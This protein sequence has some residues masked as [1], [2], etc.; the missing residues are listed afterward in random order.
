MV[1]NV[2]SLLALAARSA[3]VSDACNCTTKSL[4][5]WEGWP[6]SLREDQF[7]KIGSLVE[8]A[9]EDSTLDEYHP[10]GTSFWSPEAPI[11]A[12]Y[13]PYNRC[14]LWECL[15]CSRVY[16]HY[17]DDGAYHSESRVRALDPLLIVDVPL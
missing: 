1:L 16:L 13:Y 11:A 17:N 7:Q 8:A 14:D 4:V 6:A 3:A 10:N 9:K 2:A 5:G 15:K 12:R